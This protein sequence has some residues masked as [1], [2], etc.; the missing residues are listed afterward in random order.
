MENTFQSLEHS[1]DHRRTRTTFALAKVFSTMAKALTNAQK[2]EWAK[3]LYMKENLTQQEIAERAGVSRTSLS[4]W[5]KDGK[6]EE[7]KVG[8]TLTKDMQIQNLYRQIAEIN[9][10]IST[11]EP[12]SG[13]RFA[14]PSEADTIGKLSAAI[15]KL[16]GDIG[17]AD[18]V[19]VGIKF[20]E[21]VRKA[22]LGKAKELV[23]LWDAFLKEQM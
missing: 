15:K 4:K 2:K 5:I 11:R 10:A 14:T 23:A 19:A 8:L 22:D 12:E 7:L 6:W 17:I 16:E 3:H 21:W 20:V 18:Y 1:F 9:T 13:P